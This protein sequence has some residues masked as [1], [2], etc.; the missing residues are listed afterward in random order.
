MVVGESK[1]ED[2]EQYGG[3]MRIFLSYI[4]YPYFPKYLPS[5]LSFPLPLSDQVLHQISPL[6]LCR[7]P[8]LFLSTAVTC[9]CLYF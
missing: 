3:K 7:C 9:R 2:K 6:G 5:T 8:D 1:T 4:Q